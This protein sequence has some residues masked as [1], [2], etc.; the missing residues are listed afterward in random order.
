M[1]HCSDVAT[2]LIT[3]GDVLQVVGNTAKILIPVLLVGAVIVGVFAAK[4]YNEG[5]ECVFVPAQIHDVSS[6]FQLIQCYKL[7]RPCCT[8]WIDLCMVVDAS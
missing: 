7:L 2:V 8:S 5:A 1:P 4:T 3:V 6:E